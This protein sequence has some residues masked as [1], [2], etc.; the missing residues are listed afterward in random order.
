MK[1]VIVNGRPRVGKDQFVD[2]CLNEL[3]NYG[4]LISSVDFV[5]EIARQCGW[6]G[7]KTP[8]NRKFLSDLKD[9]LTRW[10]DV[11]YQKVIHE[12]NLF[13]YD[14]EYY[15]VEK[16]G[17]VFIM[18]RE[19]EEILKFHRELGAIT[20]L[21]IRRAVEFEQ[22]SNHADTEVYNYTYDYIIENNGTL[23]ELEEKAKNFLKSI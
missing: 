2:F 9:L 16:N 23:D 10:G 13:K 6:D 19:P 18:C 4:K 1:Y 14:L 7:S 17:V 21:I 20:V 15:E 22:Q 8:K 3:G 11:P 5:K 12:I